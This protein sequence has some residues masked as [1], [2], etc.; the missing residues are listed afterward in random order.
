MSET[1]LQM[2]DVAFRRGDSVVLD[3]IDWQVRAGEHW[4][5]LGPNGCGKTTLMMVATGYV[6]SSRGRVFLLDGYMSEIAL[7]RVRQRVGLASAALHDHML[8]HRR[9]TS[10]LEVVL[11]GRHASLGLFR[12]PSSEEL[13]RAEDLLEQFGAA[14]LRDVTFDLM[15]TGQRQRCMV[16]R[17][18]MAESDLV[19][20]DE[21]CAGLDIAA[22][23]N[24]LGALRR[25]CRRHAQTPHIL[26]T[27]HPSEIVPEITHVLL[28]REGRVVARGPKR[29]VLTEPNLEETYRMPLR[30]IR[31]DGRV[32]VLP[33][34]ESG[35]ASP[36]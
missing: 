20:L 2:E 3:G 35:D 30:V 27:H 10:G 18:Y 34:G 26:V 14:D 16:A 8:R 25:A 1:R 28:L 13:S 29:E 5:V 31:D 4:A 12:R 36:R 17:C 19:I 32:W 7:P 21:P 15:S 33:E 24:L 23:E 22:R 11:G 9:K 6:P